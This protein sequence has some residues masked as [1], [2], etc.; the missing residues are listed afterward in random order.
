MSYTPIQTSNMKRNHLFVLVFTVAA[1]VGCS[2]TGTV[3]ETSKLKIEIDRQMNTKISSRAGNVSTVLSDFRPTEY[4][5][6]NGVDVTDFQV[7]N[8]QEEVIQ[9]NVGEGSRLTITGKNGSLE[10]RLNI[11]TYHAFPS[12]AVY[13][14]SYINA[15]DS[16]LA[17]SRW[18]NH[19]YKLKDTTPDTY[20]F[21]FWSYQSESTSRR[22]DW[23]LPVTK[24]FFRQN[25]QGMNNSD[26]GG[27]TPVLSIWRPD[28]GLA[29]GHLEMVPKL[30]SMP[31]SMESADYVSFHMVQEMDKTLHAGEELTTHQTFVRVQQG[32]YFESL[33]EYRKIMQNK[34]ITFVE[35]HESA[36]EP[37]W[38][39]WGYEREFT[40]DQVY[41]ALPKVDE[42]HYH[43]AV[44][45][46][47][48]QTNVG[49]WELDPEKYPLGD[50]DM[51]EFVRTVH[52]TGIRSKIW[53]APLAMHPTSNVYHDQ[54]DWLLLDENQEPHTISW[55]DSYYMCPAHQPVID[56]H[57]DLVKT[58]IDT[59]GYHGIKID[60]QHLNAAPEC[61]NPAHNHARPEESFEAMGL[62]FRNIFN[63]AT[64]YVDDALIEIC[65][66]GT[67][68][69]FHI[70]P[71]MTQAV[72]SDPTSSWQV[73][74]KGKTLKALM[75]RSAPYFGDHVELSRAGRD[76][77]S[78]VGIGAVIGTKFTWPVGTGPDPE[79][80]LDSEREAYWAKWSGIYQEKQLAKGVYLGELY[81]IGFDR[82]ETHAIEKDGR[83]YYGMY[84]DQNPGRHDDEVGSFE[85]QVVLRGLR[86]NITYTIYD[87]ENGVEYGTVTGPDATMQVSFTNHLLLEAIPQ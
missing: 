80:D 18:V 39:A 77:A 54:K 63:E 14:V 52:E 5:T 65:P 25:F 29:V 38:C 32:D 28:A 23:V 66:C 73:R 33:V 16:P 13:E 86:E 10:K 84:A 47:G 36:Y 3:V 9:D 85:G 55:W 57:V 31:V 41:G 4:V 60:G 51:I 27:G 75:G 19:H 70:L 21:P 46:D 42:L 44:L 64:K 34:G 15:G 53:W 45:D 61:H 74:H 11:S 76:F 17:I 59:W 35:P 68:Y 79:T 20:E 58:M 49:D 2:E 82:P 67:S 26:Y 7:Q 78:Q 48:W 40:M 22:E 43:W 87:Y 37:Q 6:A 30:V 72:A 83:M 71:Y 81:D 62:L 50:D 12:V 24:G 1:L 8:V 69:A 56:Y